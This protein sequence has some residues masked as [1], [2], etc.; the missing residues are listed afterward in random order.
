M[1]PANNNTNNNINNII[2]MNNNNNMFNNNNN[3]EVRLS[4]FYRDAI[5]WYR[6]I[7]PGCCQTS[8]PFD[9]SNTCKCTKAWKVYQNNALPE[10]AFWEMI[11]KC[12]FTEF[13]IVNEVGYNK[14]D[15]GTKIISYSDGSMLV[16]NET[17]G[18][19]LRIFQNATIHL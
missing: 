16:I 15:N 13:P 2:N 6:D 1:P 5:D 11:N 8:P 9:C 12:P 17:T 19:V 14:G 4:K 18:E 7:W 3:K 10:R